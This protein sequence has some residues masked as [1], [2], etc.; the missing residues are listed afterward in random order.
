MRL[1][2]GSFTDEENSELREAFDSI[3]K[4]GSGDIELNDQFEGPTDVDDFELMAKAVDAQ[5]PWGPITF[6]EFARLYQLV[7][8][9][10]V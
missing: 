2:F 6:E 10:G 1:V 4:D 5:N 9:W 3:D 7:K 8:G